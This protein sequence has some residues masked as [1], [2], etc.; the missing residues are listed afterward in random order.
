MIALESKRF[1][2]EINRPDTNRLDS[3]GPKATLMQNIRHAVYKAGQMSNLVAVEEGRVGFPPRV[4]RML[5]SPPPTPQT[6]R[7]KQVVARAREMCAKCNRTQLTGIQMRQGNEGIGSRSQRARPTSAWRLWRARDTVEQG[8]E[9]M[10][11]TIRPL[12][13]SRSSRPNAAGTQRSRSGSTQGSNQ[14]AA[15]TKPSALAKSSYAPMS[16]SLRGQQHSRRIP[17]SRR[18]QA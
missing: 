14:M 13:Q 6:H 8:G 12:Q 4:C 10:T 5:L 11:A 1:Y 2:P 16:F 18:A 15:T 9:A 3:G 17:S 7:G